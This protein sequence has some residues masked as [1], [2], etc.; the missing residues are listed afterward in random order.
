MQFYALITD[1]N[2]MEERRV[3][4]LMKLND[5]HWLP[6]FGHFLPGDPL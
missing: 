5:L 2:N 4:V 1:I 6:L 3:S